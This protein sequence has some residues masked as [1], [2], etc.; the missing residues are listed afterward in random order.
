MLHFRWKRRRVEADVRDRTLRHHERLDWNDLFGN[1]TVAKADNNSLGVHIQGAERVLVG[2]DADGG[3]RA[4]I[5]AIAV[6]G[7]AYDISTSS[8]FRG[9]ALQVLQHIKAMIVMSAF[10]SS[11]FR[12]SDA[13]VF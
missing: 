8:S 10:S 7:W 5:P 2:Q 1:P 12:H 13:R 4:N 9:A 6:H 3:P 11:P